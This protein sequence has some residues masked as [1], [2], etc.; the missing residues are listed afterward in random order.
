LFIENQNE[1]DFEEIK[2][3]E[4]ESPIK[5]NDLEKIG[6]LGL[7]HNKIEDAIKI[8]KKYSEKVKNQI[9]IID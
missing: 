8:V 2:G 4:E 7:N 1:D 5:S 6:R 3:H 9:G